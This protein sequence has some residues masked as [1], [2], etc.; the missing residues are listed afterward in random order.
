MPSKT[1]VLVYFGSLPKP[2]YMDSD[3]L[4]K[5]FSATQ[6]EGAVWFDKIKS[7][8]ST[9][10]TFLRLRFRTLG[11]KGGFGSQLRAQGNKMS[12][13]KRAGDF[14]SYRDLTGKRIR[15][16]GQSRKIEEHVNAVS[17]YNNF[18][19]EQTRNKMEAIVKREPPKVDSNFLLKTPRRHRDCRDDCY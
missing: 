1:K 19:K 3:V 14:S 17:E 2:V 5:V 9:S 11:G 4:F 18:L 8:A 13:K 16:I 7:A 6:L 12:S 10:A 15:T